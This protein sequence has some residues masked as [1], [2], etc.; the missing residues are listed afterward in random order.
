MIIVLNTVV[1]LIKDDDNDNIHSDNYYYVIF[2]Y[3][4]FELGIP[5]YYIIENIYM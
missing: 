5:V 2:K 3:L 4:N 1:K